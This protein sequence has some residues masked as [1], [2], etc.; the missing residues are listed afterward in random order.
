MFNTFKLIFKYTVLIIVSLR[1]I[2]IRH[3]DIT[4]YHNFCAKSSICD[5]VLSNKY[6]CHEY[7]D[8]P[9]VWCYWYISQTFWLPIVLWY[10]YMSQAFDWPLFNSFTSHFYSLN[11][12]FI[13]KSYQDYLQHQDYLQF[14]PGH[15][16]WGNILHKWTFFNKLVFK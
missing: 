3:Y 2:A 9:F 8:H 6:V 14:F 16:L 10:G 12:S 15:A 13:F 7:F 1:E 11:C 5:I 4:L